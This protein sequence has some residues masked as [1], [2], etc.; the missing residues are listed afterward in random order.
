MSKIEMVGGLIRS[1]TTQRHAINDILKYFDGEDL[2]PKEFK[3][4]ELPIS[5]IRP[6]LINLKDSEVYYAI[7]N[8]DITNHPL[9]PFIKEAAVTF[10]V[11][12]HDREIPP[13]TTIPSGQLLHH[14]NAHFVFTSFLNVP[15]NLGEFLDL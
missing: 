5:I 12:N 14:G 4:V 8:V 9:F 1:L 11:V 6:R 2:N 3:D 13:W 15:Q 7:R 10:D